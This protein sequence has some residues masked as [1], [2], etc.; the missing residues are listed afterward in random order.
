MKHVGCVRVSV[1]ARLLK[2]L[3]RRIC[4][5]ESDNLVGMS[6]CVESN[7]LVSVSA[8]VESNSLVSVS[9]CV[10]SNNLMS[11]SAA[12]VGSNSSVVMSEGLRD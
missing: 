5:I 6:A 10:G 1:S 9:A 2:K 11:A 4:L 8:C 7:S 3:C 12:C